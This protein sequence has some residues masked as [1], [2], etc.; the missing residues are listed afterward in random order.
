MYGL[1]PV[2]CPIIIQA[3]RSLERVMKDLRLTLGLMVRALRISAGFTQEELG[4]K[5]GLSYKFIGE[6]ERGHVNISIDSL[7][8]IAMALGVN[9]RDLLPKGRFTARPLIV[10]KKNRV[11]RLSSKDIQTVKKA[12]G[13][14]KKML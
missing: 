4:E 5:A 7:E 6:L 2:S 8:K 11:E 10:K 14:L 12:I 13:I 9:V 1:F 3:I